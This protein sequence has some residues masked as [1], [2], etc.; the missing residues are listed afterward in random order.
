MK[1]NVLGFSA[2]TYKDGATYTAWCPDLDVA[3]QGKDIPTATANL[4]EAIELHIECLTPNEKKEIMNRQGTKFVTT[5]QVAM[6]V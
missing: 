3:S 6:P 1:T 4:R 5:L 2:V